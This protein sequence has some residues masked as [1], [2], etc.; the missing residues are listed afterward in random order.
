MTLKISETRFRVF[1][2]ILVG[3]FAILTGRLWFLQIT[4][5]EEN[6]A[7][8]N[9]FR[10]YAVPIKAPRGIMFDRNGTELVAS[11]LAHAVSVVPEVIRDHSD[12]I[13]HLASILG[14]SVEELSKQIETKTQ[15]RWRKPNEPIRVASDVPSEVA[16]RIEEARM[17]LPGVEVT[18][19]PVRDYIYGSL[20][21]HIVGYISEIN[22]EELDA[23]AEDEYKQGD[24]IG[25]TG[26]E[27]T[28]EKLLRG[29]DGSTQMEVD[30]LGRLLQVLQEVY[31]T[32]GNNLHLTI[33]LELQQVTEKALAEQLEHIRKNTR[34]KKA[35]S[36][37]VVVMDPHN[38]DILAMVSYPAYDPNLFVGTMPVDVSQRLFGDPYH[39]FTNRALL[40]QYAPGSVFKPVT[41]ASALE[42]AKADAHDVFRCSGIDAVS[43]KKCWVYN[44]ATGSHGRENLIDGLKNSCN[45][46]MY[47][48]ARRV[49]VG[50]LAQYA[51]L[52]GLGAPTGLDLYPGEKAGLV[53]DEAYKANRFKGDLAIWR[54]NETLDLSIGQGFLLTTPI[55][56][57]QMYSA[58]AN[59]GTLYQPRLVTA[60][61]TPEGKTYR[62]FHANV[63]DEFKLKPETMD[64]ITKGLIKVASEGTAS[65]TF[66]NFPLDQY[67]VAAKTGTAEITGSDNNAL[68]AAYAPAN[69]P[70]IVIVVVIEQG[71]S[72]SS[73]AGPVAARILEH[74]FKVSPPT[75]P[76]AE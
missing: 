2:G 76:P 20:G 53:P 45:I 62:E 70:S 71:G 30:K 39:P 16:M 59:G 57:A 32:P 68:F 40:G 58:I 7:K 63:K 27:R 38:G 66:R 72:G 3:V 1:A 17:D 6:L 25:K 55:Q 46:V 37:S 64:I 43:N 41:V 4:K 29:K 42:T 23:L 21:A 14:V 49:G 9:R 19:E 13:T 5:G 44:S 36:G 18:R 60:I 15:S 67:P 61:T 73:S 74:Y 69:N 26:L 35:N 51:R 10:T 31:P 12:I 28:Y 24:N 56:L 75:S 50:T 48:L 54:P 52:F 33:D 8:S 65:W 11:R 47:D 22:K 34:Y